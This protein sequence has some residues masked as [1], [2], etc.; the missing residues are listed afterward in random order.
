MTREKWYSIGKKVKL[1]ES[2][3]RLLD[4]LFL[5]SGGIV[6]NTLERVA[7]GQNKQG[8]QYVELVRKE[9]D[10]RFDQKISEIV[11]EMPAHL[12]GN[13]NILARTFGGQTRIEEVSEEIPT[14]S[15]ER[16]ALALAEIELGEN[17]RKE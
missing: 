3:V 7:G 9:L 10:R 8:R 17:I 16:V 15:R 11:Y 12:K 13:G 6:K 5:A 4:S 14:R 2:E 1:K